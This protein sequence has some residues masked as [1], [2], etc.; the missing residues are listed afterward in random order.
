MKVYARPQF[1][2]IFSYKQYRATI[3]GY[4][5]FT[6]TLGQ[7]ILYL[8]LYFCLFNLTKPILTWPKR[9]FL[10]ANQ[11]YMVFNV[12]LW[13]NSFEFLKNVTILITQVTIG[14]IFTVIEKI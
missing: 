4:I 2:S 14:T 10:W 9:A 12:T 6:P 5:G 11:V 1:S 3:C 7:H 8:M 13:G